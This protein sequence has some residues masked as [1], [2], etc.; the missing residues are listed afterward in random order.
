MTP[1][2][3]KE[4]P[5]ENFLCADSCVCEHAEEIVQVR[6]YYSWGVPLLLCTPLSS[7]PFFCSLCCILSLD[8]CHLCLLSCYQA[9]LLPSVLPSFCL[10]SIFKPPNNMLEFS[11]YIS[12]RNAKPQC[13]LGH[14]LLVLLYQVTRRFH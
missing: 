4:Q 10:A 5:V 11:R 2:L 12:T 14:L 7:L 8:S 13:I 3:H 6:Q 9:S 1:W